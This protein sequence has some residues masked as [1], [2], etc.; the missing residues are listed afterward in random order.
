M[1]VRPI[2]EPASPHGRVL[3]YWVPG[4]PGSARRR[5]LATCQDLGRAA[6]TGHVELWMDVVRLLT[7]S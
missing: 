3:L 4:P 1:H 7:A 5:S 2:A 6:G